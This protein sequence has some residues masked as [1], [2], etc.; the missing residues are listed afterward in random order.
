MSRVLP[1][2]K[3]LGPS[4]AKI[5]VVGEAPGEQEERTGIPFIG[6]SGQELS[7][8]LAEAGID[9]NQC[10]LTNVL[11]TRPPDNKLEKFCVSAKELKA[12]G[13]YPSRYNMPSLS[14][15][16]YLHPE[17]IP[18]VERLESE[19]SAVRPNVI[20]A[21]GGTALW[22]ITRLTGISKLRGTVQPSEWGKV[23]PTFHPAYIMRDWSARVICVADLLK[24]ERESHFPE[25]RRPERYILIRPTLEEIDEWIE[26]ASN[27]PVLSL[28]VETK[29]KQ[30]TEFGAAYSESEAMSIPFLNYGAANRSY[31]SFEDE[32]EVRRKIQ[33]LLLLPAKKLFQNGLYDLQY[34]LKEG[35]KICNVAED[36]MLQHHALYPEKQK[37]L[38]FLGSIYTNESSWKL[39]RKRGG[40]DSFKREDD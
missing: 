4:P 12:L 40:E 38:G 7:D 11:W 9:R 32:M 36:T 28:D 3:A 24:A 33:R 1:C 30:I 35:Y 6:S 20:I 29:S 27:W 13:G 8:M 25:I 26:E 37:S 2:M 22:A 14:Q 31:W 19:L 16:K 5:M 10:Y 15:G 23:L 39:L 17:F 21:L 34:L 18:E